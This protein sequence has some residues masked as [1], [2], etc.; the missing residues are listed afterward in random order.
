M[1]EIEGDSSAPPSYCRLVDAT[2]QFRDKLFNVRQE[3][4]AND[5]FAASKGDESRRDF[6][7]A[8]VWNLSQLG[9]ELGVPK[10]RPEPRSGPEDCL[11]DLAGVVPSRSG[12]VATY[13]Q[14]RPQHDN[15]CN[16]PASSQT[17]KCDICILR[18]R[19]RLFGAMSNYEA[20]VSQA[21]HVCLPMSSHELPFERVRGVSLPGPAMNPQKTEA[22]A[23]GL[24]KAGANRQQQQTRQSAAGRGYRARD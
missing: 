11:H 6:G 19:L 22:P 3:R 5:W 8:T 7:F 14:N 20:E 21:A 10:C 15:V 1:G 2:Q 17:T 12:R 23:I 9:E 13:E 18:S 24:Q 16:H 4:S